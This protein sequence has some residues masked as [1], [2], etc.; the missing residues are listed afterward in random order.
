MKITEKIISIPPYI[1]TNWE[2]IE[3][4]HMKG[5]NLVFTLKDDSVITVKDLPAH[6]V[7]QILNS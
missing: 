7:E 4:I 6:I 1:S 3:H 2:N 5:T